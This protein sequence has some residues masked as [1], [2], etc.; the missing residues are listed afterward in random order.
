MA[1]G[2]RTEKGRSWYRSAAAGA[3]AGLIGRA[4]QPPTMV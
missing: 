3:A 1:V 2:W 4:A